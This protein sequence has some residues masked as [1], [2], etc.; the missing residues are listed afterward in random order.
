MSLGPVEVMMI[1]FPGN[2]FNGE[3]RVELQRQIDAGVIALIDGLLVQ[4]DA[5]GEVNFAELSDNADDEHAKALA[6][7]MTR[8]EAL[9]SDDDVNQLA[10]ALAPSSSAAIMVFEHVW[11]QGLRDAVVASDGELLVNFRVPSQAIDELQAEL[12]D[13][14]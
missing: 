13:V 5:D 10:E 9:I 14:D 2:R 12:A 4:K 8:R 6:D 3:I 1:G 11:A 7:A